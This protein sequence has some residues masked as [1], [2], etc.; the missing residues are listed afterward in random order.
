MIAYE[1][2][3]RRNLGWGFREGSM[4]FEKES[5]VHETLRKIAARLD[6]LGIPYALVGG[7]ALFFHG[8]QRFTQDVD[9]LVTPEGLR[10]IQMSA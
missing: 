9:L 3:L 4:H 10:L 1:D 2:R 8:Y 6:G 7:M 5:A